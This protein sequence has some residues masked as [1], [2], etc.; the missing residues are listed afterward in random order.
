MTDSP[1]SHPTHDVVAHALALDGVTRV[2]S[3]LHFGHPGT[4]FS[5]VDEVLPLLDGAHR[6]ILNGDTTEECSRALRPRSEEMFAEFCAESSRRG[7]ELLRIRGN[8]DAS[9]DHL[10]ALRLFGGKVLIIHGDACYHYG[11]PWSRWIPSL[12]E[13]LDEV[14]FEFEKEGVNTLED[15][16]RLAR[17][18]ARRYHPPVK[19]TESKLAGILGILMSAAWPP[20]VAWR[21]IKERAMTIS[22]AV[23]F[24]DYFAPEAKVMI[25]GHI[26]RS[27]VYQRGEKMLINTGAFQPV[28]GRCVCD[29]DGE[30]ITVRNVVRTGGKF[31]LGGVKQTITWRSLGIDPLLDQGEV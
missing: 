23:E 9:Q 4:L 25:F 20:T 18:W 6:V 15:R 26:H 16:L 12:K 8:H 29:L 28:A 19:R 22:R 30:G 3:D 17:A 7:V 11:S 10:G 13:E 5:E 31:V 21:L 1:S 14:Y 2:I 27:G 24:L